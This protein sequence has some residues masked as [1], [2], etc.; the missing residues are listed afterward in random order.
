MYYSVSIDQDGADLTVGRFEL[1]TPV[2]GIDFVGPDHKYPVGRRGEDLGRDEDT[3]RDGAKDG[4]G[5]SLSR[6]PTNIQ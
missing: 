4:S 1:G 2:H 3:V 6:S 5:T